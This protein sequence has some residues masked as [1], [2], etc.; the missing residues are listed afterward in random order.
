MLN[1]NAL[2]LLIISSAV[3]SSFIK[4]K[5]VLPLPCVVEYSLIPLVGAFADGRSGSLSYNDA[6]ISKASCTTTLW[7]PLA[8][9]IKSLLES[10]VVIK[11]SII[12][13]VSNENL[14]G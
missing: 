8:L 14:F 4:Y 7:G 12:S 6:V 5:P 11:L 2:F 13:I 10:V 9:K 1:S 3:L